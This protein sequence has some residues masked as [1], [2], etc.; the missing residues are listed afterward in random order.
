MTTD[1]N[2]LFAT[3]HTIHFSSYHSQSVKMSAYN[4][5]VHRLLSI[6]LSDEDYM[7]EIQIIKHMAIVN[8]YNSGM[9][10]QLI[11]KHSKK[12]QPLQLI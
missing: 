5:L 8:G 3:D 9:V 11:K 4:S 6:P 7:N 1:Y 10:E 12:M 2:F